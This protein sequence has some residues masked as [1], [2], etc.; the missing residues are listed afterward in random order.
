MIDRRIE[1]DFSDN[2]E[3]DRTEIFIPAEQ[4][5]SEGKS[6]TGTINRNQK[7][8]LI[9]IGILCVVFLVMGILQMRDILNIPLAKVGGGSQYA[10]G[11][12][13]QKQETPEE[14]KG[15]DSD[16]D[17]ISDYDELY[18]YLTSP[19]LADSDS[20]G[21]TDFEEIK[22]GE[23]PNCPKGMECFRSSGRD[24]TNNA[25]PIIDVSAA[26]SV[27]AADLRKLLISSGQFTPEQINSLDDNTLLEMYNITLSENPELIQEFSK[28]PAPI[29]NPAILSATEIRQLL[30]DQGMNAT[31]VSQIDDITLQQMYQEAL[32][33]AS[34]QI[35][36]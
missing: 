9:S 20:D 21:E 12:Q 25:D 31:D 2:A 24:Q 8:A 26:T 36:N 34:E 19:Y 18:I 1:A 16:D 14:L 22:K 6:F 13:V 30:I 5:V 11:N 17:G 28:T 35:K 10:T 32:Q 29:V 27:S 4:R 33:Y 3:P 23:D 7:I 15:R